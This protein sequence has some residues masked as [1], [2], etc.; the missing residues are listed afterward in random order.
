M[1]YQLRSYQQ[2]MVDI[3]VKGLKSGKK[4]F[5]LQAATG[6]LSAN[7]PI[8]MADG[9]T[10]PVGSIKSGDIVLSYDEYTN[11]TVQNI[12]GEVIR[13]S[14][15]PKPMIELE[16]E[17]ETIKTT[18]DHPFYNGEGFYPLYQLIWREMETSQRIQLKLLC[19]Q[20]GAPFNNEMVRGLHSCCNETCP[21]CERLFKNNDGRK[22][23]KTT[24]D[25]S[26]KLVGK[27]YEP[28]ISK[29]YFWRKGRQLGAEPGMVFSEIQRL[30]RHKK[31]FY[32]ETYSSEGAKSQRIGQGVN[33]AILSEEHG[34]S[35]KQ[36]S[37]DTTLRQVAGNVPT[38][39]TLYYSEM[40][41][42]KIKVKT[43]EPY[44]SIC[45]R[46]APH[47]YY[48][49]EKHSF[50]THN[51][52]KSLVIAG[53]AHQLNEPTLILQPSLELLV[54]NYEK[55]QSFGID[56]VKIYSAS[57]GVKE[58]GQYVMATI[59]SI[60]KK[61]ELFKQFKHIIMDECHLYDSKN[62]TGMLSSFIKAIGCNSVCGLTATPYRIVQKYTKDEHN[63]LFY[64]AHLKCITRIYPF[65]FRSIDYKIETQ[66]LIDM[67]YLS[68]VKYY[69]DNPDT[70][71][72][73][74][75]STGRDFTDESM[76]K[77]WDDTKLR[78]IAQAVE[79][80]DKHHKCSLTFC[81]SILQANR[82]VSLV[83]GLGVA[84]EVIDGKT[85]KK[86]R[87]RLVGAYKRLEIKHLFNVG[88]FT[89]GF[90]APMLDCIILARPTMSLALH[91]Q[92]VGRGVR[93]DPTNKDKVLSVYD[94]CGTT[95]RLGKVES[96]R[97]QTEKGGFRD[98]VW[99]N[100]VRMD[101]QPLFRWLVK[102]IP[103]NVR[104]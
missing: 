75:N 2:D 31:W 25:S 81:S 99:S 102:N 72:L 101:E 97:V 83:R 49:G 43:S 4:P 27:S 84:C 86:E 104:R 87:E 77:F 103:K 76:N 100:G 40:G 80:A 67:G 98:E 41:N 63:N 93:L 38:S 18:Y 16:Y 32:Q 95:R 9:T 12:V 14:L 3:G 71:R 88:V 91:Y 48:I 33:T 1:S 60:Y 17:D 42:R 50:V 73:K 23:C 22:D 57:A 36:N 61:P 69:V 53:I 85:P 7:T 70:S 35:T 46:T 55:M 19:E 96:I 26:R 15:K 74:L 62:V 20:Y 58:I 44:Y 56:D 68:P 78:R 45:M 10:K 54:Q 64:T 52:G 11:E 34:I 28:S 24:Q 59:G 82:A 37:K 8:R 5:I 29:S 51:S 47:T 66:E 65:F 92:I 13:T 39:V 21:R 89:T 90:D 6:C 94:L 30:A 79:Y